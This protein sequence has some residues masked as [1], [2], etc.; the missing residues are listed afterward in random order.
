LSIWKRLQLLLPSRRRAEERDMQEELE[1]LREMAEPHELGNLT[2]VAEDA[3]A[4]WTWTWFERLG[5]DLRYAGR[6]ML[7][8]KTFTALAA[9]S[10][11]LGIGANTAIYSF[12]ESILLRSL[13]VSDPESLVVMKWRAEQYTSA[14]SSGMSFSTGGTSIDPGTGTIGSQF[15]YPALEVFQ[16]STEVLSSAFCYF[17]IDRLNVTV[18]QET[19]VAKGQYVSGDYFRGMGVPPSAG[20][21][22]LA[23][24]DEPGAATVAVLSHRYSQRRFGDA[25]QT[26]GR[27]IRIND[28]PVTVIGVAPRGFFGAEPG[29]VPDVYIPIRAQVVLE[30]P[31]VTKDAGYQYL[32][33]NYYWIEIMGR[34]KTGVTVEQAQAALAPQFGAFVNATAPTERQRTDLP[35]LRIMDGSA[36]LD[37]IRRR[38]AK[39]VYA[40]M[41][42]VGLILLIACANV[43]NLLLSRAMSRR[44]EIA[45]RLSIGASRMRVVRQ[46]LTESV[47]LSSI[48]GLLGVL[49]AWWGI[50]VL[51]L[52]LASGRENFT[53]HAELNWH[54]LGATLVLSA[55]TGV[56][57]GLAPALQATRVDVMPAL[58]QSKTAAMAGVVRGRRVG[59][60][61][62]LVVA[63]IAFSLVLLVA[64]GLFAGTLS[65][66]HAIETG[67]S[68]EGVLLF[69]L[70]ARSAGYEGPALT[71]V[72]EDLRQGLRQVPGV[73]NA[74]LSSRPLPARGG[75]LVPVTVVGVPAPPPLVPGGSRRNAAGVLSVAPEFFETMR[76]PRIA[77]REFDERDTAGA[78]P[79]AIINQKLASALSLE[80]P[81]GRRISIGRNSTY[82]VVGVVADALFLNLKEE[83][84]PMVYFPYLQGSGPASMTYEV[85]SAGNPLAL[86]GTI[87]QMVR[88][89][90]TRLAVSDV[91]TQAVHIDQEISQ[92]ITLA[93]LC[94]GFALLALII[95][96]VGLY[97]TVAFSVSHRVSEIG[98]RVALGAQPAGI[99]WLFLR[100]VLTLELV[101]LAIGVPAVLVGSRYLESLLFGIKPNDPVVVAA[102]I[103]I[104]LTAGLVA[105]YVPARRASSVDPMVALRNE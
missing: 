19:E 56:L 68:R 3:R 100:S 50:G 10:L 74:S 79:V 24:D 96:C 16:R 33:P 5:Q 80:N 9:L 30:P 31:V 15:P 69:T 6:A 42:M 73:L 11:A 65:N 98:V 70:R 35:E 78:A 4:T 61:Q 64:A 46:M 62:A 54:V 102:G 27:N 44:R 21:F 91:K 34:L 99:V 51:T 63:Q 8:D 67:F 17:V 40:L 36:G 29:S 55:L 66:L 89:L 81:V 48:G 22:I 28:K 47:V 72:Y 37:S 84:R 93:R 45:V 18:N 20:R 38:Y 90:D 104:L 77:G 92:E 41:T 13:P 12:T 82:E 86:V 71:R 59:L 60:S 23:T 7:H 26:V 105:S 97:G 2:V 85:R 43:A 25:A 14:A 88:Q 83:Q 52:L 1:S 75:T 32:D 57:F 94:T 101:G 103:L 58:K 95:A 39:P 87:R 49:F 53:L 76:I